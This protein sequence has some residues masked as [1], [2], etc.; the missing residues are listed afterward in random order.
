MA[1]HESALTWPSVQRHALFSAMLCS[2][3]CFGRLYGKDV[4][5]II[6]MLLVCLA[7]ATGKISL[8][9]SISTTVAPSMTKEYVLR[10]LFHPFVLIEQT[11][12]MALLDNDMVLLFRVFATCQILETWKDSFAVEV[13]LAMIS[14]L[15]KSLMHSKVRII[16]YYKINVGSF[17]TP[18][19]P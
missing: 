16:T 15:W 3:P 8:P 11:K 5:R 4:K 19:P 1:S 12:K 10:V 6:V 9:C 13:I 17:R 7:A 2:A 18:S 14:S